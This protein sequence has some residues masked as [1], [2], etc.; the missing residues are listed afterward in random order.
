M[1]ISVAYRAAHL[2]RDGEKAFSPR[3]Y[4][5][6]TELSLNVGDMV[7]APTKYGE[8]PAVVRAINQPE[9]TFECKEVTI[10]LPEA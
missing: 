4:T 1:F 9:P 7:V 6:K 10:R 5:Y 3:T 8:Q 2:D